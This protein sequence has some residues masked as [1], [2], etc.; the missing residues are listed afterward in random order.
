M[1]RTL[2]AG[3]VAAL[4]ALPALAAQVPAGTKLLPAEQ[5]TFIR[6]IGT[7]PASIDPQMVEETAGSKIVN[8]LF[9]GL[10]TLDGDGKLQLVHAKIKRTRQADPVYLTWTDNGVLI[11]G[12]SAAAA[13]TREEEAKSDRDAVLRAMLAAQT[14][15]ITVPAGTRGPSNSFR[16]L[17]ALSEM[18][19]FWGRNGKRR[20]D[21]ALLSLQS[22]NMIARREECNEHRNLRAHLEL[23]AMGEAAARK[24]AS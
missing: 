3:T 8:D 9:E 23:T 10:Y 17:E 6:N 22:E 24:F 7:E 13:A 15:S 20:F 12:R 4:F 16:T 11:P 21:T 1:K 19:T 18:A 5:Q 14:L 2:I